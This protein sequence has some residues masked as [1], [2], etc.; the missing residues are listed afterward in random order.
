MKIIALISLFLLLSLSGFSQ[1][2][3]LT[4]SLTSSGTTL[5][6]GT[7]SVLTATP[8]SGTA[9]YTYVW[10][11]G[12]TTSSITVNKPGTYTVSV[13]DNTPGCP[14]VNKSIT[15]TSSTAPP[16]PTAASQF[17]CPGSTVTLT[18]TAP[19][20][21]YEWYNVPTGGMLLDTGANYTTPPVTANT[22]YY[23][24][25][26][27]NGCTS[28]RT[29]VG[30]YLINN[31]ATTGDT[32]CLGSNAVLTASGSDSYI[33]YDSLSGDSVLS[34]SSTLTTPPL[35]TTTTYYVSGTTSGCTSRRIAVTAT[36]T[37]PPQPPT[38]SNVS[39]CSGSVATL[40]ASSPAD[41][42]Y[43][44]F[45]TPTGG[46]SLISSPDYTTPILTATTTYYVQVRLNECVSTRTPVTVTV[47]PNPLPPANQTVTICPN[48][49]VMLTASTSPTGT[50]QWYDAAGNP[51]ATGNTYTTGVLTG[52]TTFYVQ[53]SNS[54]SCSSALATIQVNMSEPPAAPSVSAPLICSGSP[55]TLT[56]TAPGGNYE[57]FATATGVTPLFSGP[58]YTTPDLTSNTTY[59]VQT[60][61]AGCVSA[62]TAVNVTVIPPGPGPAG[63]GSTVCSGNAASLTAAGGSNSYDW[64]DA[65]GKYL[66]SGQV[67]IT[68]PL[69]ATTTYYVQTTNANGCASL[70]TPVTATVN[71]TPDAPTASGA[72]TCLGTAETFTATGTGTI[73]W[74][75]APTGGN[76]LDTGKTF[77]TPPLY[78]NITYYIQSTSSTCVSPRT[79]VST[80]V[81]FVASPQFQYPKGTY[82]PLST[83]NPT[84]TIN[85]PSGGTFSASPAGL[86]FISTTTGQIDIAT[87]LPGNY[88]IKFVGN[89]QCSSITTAPFAISPNPNSTFVYNS[90][91]CLDESNPVAT[92]PSGSSPGTFTASPAGLVFL[93]NTTGEIDFLKST[94]GTYTIYN[95][96]AASS[97]CSSSSSN[98][99]VTLYNPVTVNAGSPQIVQ[100]GVPVQLNGSV[101]GSATSGTWSGGLGT[102]SNPSSLN[103]IYTPAA[104][105]TSATLT[106]TSNDP[107]GACGPK[108]AQVTIIINSTPAAPTAKGQSVCPGSSTILSATAPG[109][110]YE[111]FSTSTGDTVLFSGAN[112]PTPPITTNTTYYVQTTVA[113]FTSSRTAVTVT[114]INSTTV[115]PSVAPV[116]PVCF[117][118]QATIT[119]SGSTSGY[120]W[121]DTATGNNLLS[122]S[123]PY[124]TPALMANTSYFVQS[125]VAGGC[126]NARTEV[127]VVVM[128]LPQITS[129]AT[130]GVCGG[131][132][133]NYA[134][135]SN[136]ASATFVWGR[137]QV[138]GISNPAA[139]NQT[140]PI[141]NETLINTGVTAVN[142]TYVITAITN[143]C[144]GPPFNYVVTVNPEPVVTSPNTAVACSGNPVNYTV[145]FNEP[146]TSFSWGRGANAG[147]SNS[148][149]SGQNSATIREVLNNTTNAP[150]YVTYVFNYKTSTCDGIPF[151]LVVRVNPPVIITSAA[152]DT[153]CSSVPESYAIQTNVPSTFSWSRAQV[154]GISNPAATNQTSPTI[155]ET[156]INTMPYA[157][158]VTYIITPMANGCSGTPFNY[159]VLVNPQPSPSTATS[160]TPVCLG[161]IIQLNTPAVARA[162][163]MWTGPNGF[164]SSEQNPTI[165]NVTTAASG[166]YNLFVI[167]NGCISAP[168]TTNVNVDEPPLANAGP[169]Q[170]ACVDATSVQLA[171]TISG[172]TTTGIWTGGSENFL[173]SAAQLNA[174][175]IP[176][177]QD[178]ANGSVTLTLRSTSQDNCTISTSSMTIKFTRVPGANAGLDQDVCSQTT[179]VKLNG[180]ILTTGGG[181]WQTLGSGNF[182]PSETALDATYMPSVADIKNDSVKLVLTATSADVC[183]FP[184]DTM[185]IYFLP[186]PTVNA[187]GTRYVLKGYTIT[188]NPTVSDKNLHYLWSPDIDIN[189][190]TLKNPVITGDVDRTYTLTVTDSRGC[191]ASDETFIKVSPQLIIPNTFTPNGDGINDLWDITGLTAYQNATVDIFNRY[192]TKLYHSVGYSVP[193]DGNYNGKPVPDGTY[194]YVIETKV[195]NQ[196]LS[197]FVE[198]VR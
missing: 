158:K 62:R 106:L 156:L 121:Y 19:G 179:A 154:S 17:V 166:T 27:V 162:T 131:T 60:T 104:G 171:G 111:W 48:S 26:T 153:V 101:G 125:D 163:Y 44:W 129:S 94:A 136:I 83:T 108:S 76:L 177:A 114:V 42:V 30:T 148:P 127:D 123:N 126:T 135:T 21:F 169:N 68:P 37:P 170:N 59:Y 140:S 172:G 9:P 159:S 86:T 173:P 28:T 144:T 141:I 147:I 41:V 56:P 138:S 57:W 84:P 29:A 99:M 175:Y 133:E 112:F 81:I 1:S 178:R 80:S 64:F 25:T 52:P 145:T 110:K 182:T 24:E 18:A 85:N 165:D 67:Y 13:S 35:T 102:F 187:G 66:S 120:Q 198:V 124:V 160:N 38:A 50:Y 174:Q 132:A 63:M 72:P 23:V 109:G 185:V 107:P 11:T 186:P 97:G 58:S 77:T 6:P 192:G 95:T 69:S 79:A 189:N 100:Q 49:S 33:W 149:V 8:S 4:V 152:K 14:S 196:I 142:V 90:S 116:P 43:D 73:Q 188:L 134:I 54:S 150:V 15:I 51:L 82:C 70:R 115:P 197:G 5:C 128:P 92:F 118:S 45:A 88:T 167:V 32:V 2:C 184:T 12:E 74:Y 161:S 98:T 20:G 146:T 39:I 155:E 65:G 194:Y 16:A 139:T 10:S 193:W 7:V 87:S 96:I 105:E 164:S 176:S 117:G 143:G 75:D 31:P 55:A 119:A 113:G 168:A 151:N 93:N 71:Q 40:H 157:V 190:D 78:N 183:Y 89:G 22:L 195:N 91:Y 53:N 3:T 61:V 180:A 181:S 46:T 137:E 103:A 191:V 34:T 122:T 36:V 47:N 130:G